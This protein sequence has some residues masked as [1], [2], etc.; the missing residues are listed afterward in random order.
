MTSSSV[1]RLRVALHNVEYLWAA[2]GVVGLDPK[3]FES[4]NENVA[5]VTA[6]HQ[7]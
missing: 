7:E 5:I 2:P 4:R 6:A 1:D 3:R